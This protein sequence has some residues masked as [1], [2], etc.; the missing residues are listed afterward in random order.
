MS[1]INGDN[2]TDYDRWKTASPD[3]EPDKE[4][5]Q[6]REDDLADIRYQEDRDR[7]LLNGEE[8]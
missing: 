6:Q 3:D 2:M 7:E 8:E 4:A 1:R 5:A